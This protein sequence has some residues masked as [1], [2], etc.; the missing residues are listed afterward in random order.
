MDFSF[1]EFCKDFPS[2]IV[3]ALEE[4]G[5]DSLPARL[6]ADR[7]DTDG[8]KLKKGHVAVVRERIKTPQLQHGANKPHGF[9]GR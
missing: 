4:D 3:E 7:H 6:S 9:C 8:L 2:G 1:S 5:F